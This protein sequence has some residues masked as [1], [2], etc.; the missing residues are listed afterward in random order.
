MAMVLTPSLKNTQAEVIEPFCGGV[1]NT[2]AQVLKEVKY[3][4][5]VGKK[6]IQLGSTGYLG[7]ILVFIRQFGGQIFQLFHSVNGTS[8]GRN[9]TAVKAN[10]LGHS[11]YSL[12]NTWSLIHVEGSSHFFLEILYQLRLVCNLSGPLA[13]LPHIEVVL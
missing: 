8:L 9:S 11:V 13:Q 4:S 10:G 1:T 7:I 2:D 5:R 6:S 3:L 12:Y